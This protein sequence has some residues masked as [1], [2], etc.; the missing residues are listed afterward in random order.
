MEQLLNGAPSEAALEHAARCDACAEALA[1]R[2]LERPC[3]AP[4]PGMAAQVLAQ[5]RDT[6]RRESLRSYS[7]RVFAA[8]AATL[9]LLFSG[10]FRFLGNLPEALEAL[11]KLGANLQSITEYFNPERSKEGLLYEF[12][13]Q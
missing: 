12:Q 3:A 4:P 2:T 5:A 10:A 11:P 7:L 6:R 13:S 1:R 8:M 9:I